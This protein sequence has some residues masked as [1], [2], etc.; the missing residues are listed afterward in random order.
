MSC[1]P[2]LLTA[3][4]F[5]LSVGI[6]T[7]AAILLYCIYELIKL[8]AKIRNP[9]NYYAWMFENLI[10]DMKAVVQFEEKN[11]GIYKDDPFSPHTLADYNVRDHILFWL[12][13]IDKVQSRNSI[14]SIGELQHVRQVIADLTVGVEVG[15]GAIKNPRDNQV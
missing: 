3:K 15:G 12:R 13:R 14:E 11:S 1:H 10:M 9:R 2:P 7:A 5:L 8:H 6:Y 4:Y